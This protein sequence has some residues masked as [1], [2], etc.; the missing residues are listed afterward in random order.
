M[1]YYT[2]Q[3][4]PKARIKSDCTRILYFL[5]YS[6][7]YS[8]G[9]AKLGRKLRFTLRY[10]PFVRIWADNSPHGPLS[11]YTPCTQVLSAP[12]FDSLLLKMF[13]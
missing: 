5:H 1:F 11:V 3:C 8:L 9:L 12:L 4:N 7:D 6:L 10:L 13:V 2:R